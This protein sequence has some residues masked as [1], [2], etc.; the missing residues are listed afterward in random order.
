LGIAAFGQ[1]ILNKISTP[2][3]YEEQ[4]VFRYTADVPSGIYDSTQIEPS[5]PIF[6]RLNGSFAINMDY[7]FI[8]TYP[9]TINGT[10]HLLAR[11][12]D[13]SGWKR[14]LELTSEESFSGMCSP[15]PER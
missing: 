6:R 1:P 15:H 10:Y 5:E 14:T 2:I 12:S 13:N 7:L 8:S 9:S 3:A 11:V 4:A